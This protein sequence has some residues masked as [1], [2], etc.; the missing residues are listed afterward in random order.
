MWN[1]RV[2]RKRSVSTDPEDQK[3]RVWYSYAIHEAYYD[4]KGFVG[5]ITQEPMDVFGEDIEELRHAWMMIAEAFGQPILDYD[6]IPEP[7]YDR[8]EDPLGSTLDKRFKDRE[9]KGIP[10]EEVKRELEAKWGPFDHEAYKREREEE[11]I[12]KEGIHEKFF[13]GTDTIE[14]LIDKI[15]SDY[16]QWR[17]KHDVALRQKT[18]NATYDEREQPTG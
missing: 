15:R 4:K 14:A 11:R 16:Q 2:V 17:N 18:P 7:G 6:R 13:V 3:E 5:A 8:R 10:W 9:E 1:Y 12:E